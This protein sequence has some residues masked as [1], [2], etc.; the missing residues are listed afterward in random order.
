MRTKC[1]RR[2]VVAFAKKTIPRI[3]F[4][5]GAPRKL[6]V[7]LHRMWVDGELLSNLVFE[8]LGHTAIWLG[9]MALIPSLNV[10]PVM[11]FVR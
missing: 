2:A 5:T 4:L 8:G 11:T 6:A 3:V 9:L 1:R 10:T 7:L